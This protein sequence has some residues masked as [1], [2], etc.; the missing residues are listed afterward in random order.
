MNTWLLH[1]LEK[2]KKKE[3]KKKTVQCIEL[4]T[5]ETKI[6]QATI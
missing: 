4:N 1:Y 6:Y 2:K 5:L 3:K